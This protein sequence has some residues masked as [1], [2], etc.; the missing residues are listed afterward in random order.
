MIPAAPLIPVLLCVVAF[1]CNKSCVPTVPLAA[2]LS[3][4]LLDPFL[5]DFSYWTSSCKVPP[6]HLS[7]LHLYICPLY[8]S[9]LFPLDLSLLEL[10]PLHPAGPPPP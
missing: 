2:A 5:L 9:P 3:F 8:H 4:S 6:L 7:P 10:F 1:L